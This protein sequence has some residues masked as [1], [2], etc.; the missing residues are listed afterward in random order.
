MLNHFQSQPKPVLGLSESIGANEI[1][2]KM[3]LNAL[4]TLGVLRDVR[5]FK[6]SLYCELDP[7]AA[8]E[9]RD[10]LETKVPA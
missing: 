8:Q 6:R 4:R 3:T 9:L 10:M 2:V 5:G 1:D 7:V